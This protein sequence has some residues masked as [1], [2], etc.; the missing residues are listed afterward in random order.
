MQR[1]AAFKA[2]AGLCVIGAMAAGLVWLARAE[3]TTEVVGSSTATWLSGEQRGRVMLITAGAL[4]PSLAIEVV[5]GGEDATAAFDIAD[6]GS[7][8]AVHDRST[9][10]LIVYDS[11]TGDE[12][13]RFAGI[14]PADE[15]ASLV[16]AGTSAYL[17]DLA[18]QTAKQ[19]TTLGP[20]GPAVPIG[21]GFTD[22][23]GTTDGTLWM[24]NAGAGLSAS[25]DGERVRH[26]RFARPDADLE[27]TSIGNDPV[28]LDRDSRLVRWLRR[29]VSD[30]A[31]ADT[32]DGRQVLIQQPDP[33]ATCA[34]VLTRDLL[35]CHE[36]SGVT[37]SIQLREQAQVLDDLRGAQLYSNGI[38]AVVAWPDRTE[39]AVIS[40][41]SGTVTAASRRTTSDRPDVGWVTG[42]TIVLDD[43]AGRYA[44]VIDHGVVSELDKFSRGTV[45][46]ANGDASVEDGFSDGS[47]DADLVAQFEGP[48]PDNAADTDGEPESP[49]ASPDRAVTRVG[50]SIT[51]GVLG[52]D[53]DPDGDQLRVVDAGP[54]ASTDGTV[55]V[56]AESVVN[57]RAPISSLDR[58]VS[59]P[60]RITDTTNRESRST[61]TVE[62]IG[63]GRNTAPSLQNDEA[64]VTSGASIDINV[65]VND[66]DD[67]GDQLS[68]IGVT[69]AR[70]GAAAINNN[71]ITYRADATATGADT[72]SYTVVDGFGGERSANVRIT[73]NAANAANRAPIA[74]DDR[75]TVTAGQPV[76]VRALDNDSDPDGDPLRIVNVTSV[77]GVSTSIRDSAIIDVTPA[78][79]TGGLVSI[80]YTI[81]DPDGLRDSASVQLSIQPPATPG[82]RGVP[83]AVD[84]QASSSGNPVVIDVVANDSDPG[85]DELAITTV[86]A[87]DSISG[88]VSRLS[89]RT[90]L[91]TPLPG[92]VG[93]TRFRY[94]VTNVANLTASATVSVTVTAPSDSGPV[95]VDDSV[96]IFTGESATI[97]V[98]ANDVHPSGLPFDLVGQPVVRGG[99][100]TV[101]A[102]NT[103]TFQPPDSSPGIYTLTYT[104]QDA[105]GRRST[106]N[107]V[108]NVVARSIAN[109]PPVATDDLVSTGFDTPITVDVAGNDVDPDGDVVTLTAFGTPSQGDA[110]LAGGRLRFEPPPGF[111]G[112]ATI[113]YTVS[114]SRGLTATGRLTVQVLGRIQIP[115]IA[116]P[117]LVVL[118]TNSQVTVNPL[119]NDTDPDGTAANLRVTQIGAVSPPGGPSAVLTTTGVQITSNGSVGT[120]SIVYTIV[121]LD[122]LTSST[123]LTV[124]VQSPPNS[125]PIAVND[126]VSLL[127]VTTNIQV[128][129]NDNDPDGGSIG[130][131][132]VGPV[133]PSG[134]GTVSIRTNG[135]SVDLTPTSGFAGE[136]TF[137]YT[138]ADNAGATATAQVTAIVSA[139]PALPV[140]SPIAAVTRFN[141]SST[142][143]LF[144]GGL[145]DG[146]LSIS[147]PGSGSATLNSSTGVVAYSPN[148]GFNGVDTFTYSVRSICGA[149]ASSTV[150]VTV[151]R[152]PS[153]RLDTTSTGRN[154]PVTINVIGNDTDPDGDTLRVV[155]VFGEVGGT[156]TSFTASSVTLQPTNG[157]TG[158]ATFSYVVEDIGGLSAVGQVEVTVANAAPIANPDPVSEFTLTPTISID[159][160]ANDTDANGDALTVTI[161][162]VSPSGVGNAIVSGGVVQFAPASLTTPSV[163]TIQYTV[164]DGLETS[165][166]TITVAIR[167]RPPT[168]VDDT[169]TLDLLTMS[170]ITVDV[171]SN[172]NDP[173]GPTSALQ[174]IAASVVGSGQAV[175]TPS[176][177]TYTPDPD[178]TGTVLVNYTVIDAYGDAST[179]TLIITIS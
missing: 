151:N 56:V 54:L 41:A 51:I 26:K 94:W 126:T 158:V 104:I 72:F 170:D 21:R 34:A 20:P 102:N 121:D 154:T 111:V 48:T 27:L 117:D 115:P 135:V 105:A 14:V 84:D 157:F 91:F 134:A 159:A 3:D 9:G 131:V 112:L 95:A 147:Q 148:P 177:V 168:A 96:T 23:V 31:A 156:I 101:N 70:R 160:K 62:I 109:R 83:I 155:N 143:D 179:G 33:T 88:S 138:I 61:V 36:P 86:E 87:P 174:V 64:E 67:E 107:V 11:A 127:A 171:L 130:I 13:T 136:I 123:T 15:R 167:N 35:Q 110:S 39:V 69:T 28:V 178:T 17:V 77:P 24:L 176:T 40:W 52:N 45:L 80:E 108:I 152:A 50:R 93:T 29:S 37:R 142:I 49:T 81:E 66:S 71:V 42:S 120:Y 106:A 12:T 53:S 55:A 149:V 133:S 19:I 141:T 175:F 82:A 2:L 6:M 78:A 8:V 18:A 128:L 79:S 5:S 145:P 161:D 163:A 162:S 85:G 129:A 44:L 92:F 74:N 98:L 103:I 90:V 144:P 76:A 122:G 68:I 119:V 22:W 1:S 169:V 65:L 153:A 10:S 172:D 164:S 125:P 59:F 100:A 137:T 30:S 4:R 146:V 173:D 97:S 99:V 116:S 118:E 124:T 25:F 60:Y 58:T 38:D 114:D 16:L 32:V 75:T 57:Y 63:S 132:A 139:C 89:P 7:H 165:S 47:D 140:L 46:L 166:S 113:S 73:I 150:S 43:P